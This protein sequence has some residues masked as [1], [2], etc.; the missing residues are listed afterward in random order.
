MGTRRRKGVKENQNIDSYKRCRH[1]Y[2]TC[3]YFEANFSISG[4]NWKHLWQI[5]V[6]SQLIAFYDSHQMS[7]HSYHVYVRVLLNSSSASYFSPRI[8][9]IYVRRT[10]LRS[11]CRTCPTPF[12]MNFNRDRNW[13]FVWNKSLACVRAEMII[14]TNDDSITVI[15]CDTFLLWIEIRTENQIAKKKVNTELSVDN[16]W[17]D[18]KYKCV[19]G[20]RRLHI[21]SID[22]N[23]F[24]NSFSRMVGQNINWKFLILFFCRQNVWSNQRCSIRCSFET[25]SRG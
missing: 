23:C 5:S 3:I 7:V 15:V 13:W 2:G 25:G 14:I 8:S 21:A 16:E 19:E 22:K 9:L 6:N 24:W 12:T 10:L 4:R 1:V 11:C 18:G 17:F 20:H